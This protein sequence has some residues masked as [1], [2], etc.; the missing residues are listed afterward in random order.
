METM[1]IILVAALALL[2]LHRQV[3]AAPKKISVLIIDGMNNH[4]WPRATAILRDILLHSGRFDV[5]V[6]T[7]PPTSPPADAWQAWN[8]DFAKYD[9]ILANFN[10][11][12]NT[13]T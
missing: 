10:G 12:Y 8:P 11:S 3:P 1:R 7:S 13:S 9:V 4:D 5:D 6:S 2:A